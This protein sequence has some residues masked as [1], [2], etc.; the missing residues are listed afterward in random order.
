MDQ[1]Q[2]HGC[3]QVLQLPA[4]IHSS[5]EIETYGYKERF[6]GRVFR[7]AAGQ[8]FHRS[9]RR[10]EQEVSGG[11][12]LIYP[13]RIRLRVRAGCGHTSDVHLEG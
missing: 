10:Q 7:G 11:Y 6:Q 13:C 2:A 8:G 1:G 4:G 5:Q 3:L 12:G 9:L